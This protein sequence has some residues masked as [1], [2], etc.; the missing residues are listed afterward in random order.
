[1]ARRVVVGVVSGQIDIHESAIDRF[2]Q[3]R[4]LTGVVRRLAMAAASKIEAS[5]RTR[6]GWH[7][8]R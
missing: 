4:R 3:P 6:H 7:E 5:P 8:L 1:M 2:R